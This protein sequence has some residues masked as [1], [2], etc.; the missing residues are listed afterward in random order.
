MY[1]RDGLLRTAYAASAYTSGLRARPI[2]SSPPSRFCTA[3]VATSVRGHS[4]LEAMPSSRISS[5]I[6]KAHNDI[7]NFAIMYAVGFSHFG[8]SRI[9]GD[10]VRMCGFSRPTM[11]GMQACDTV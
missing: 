4:V 3:A 7:P 5:A 1:S 9:G 11:C 6:A 10:S 8:S 2:A